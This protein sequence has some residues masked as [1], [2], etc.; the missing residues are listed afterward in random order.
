LI[1]PT[2]VDADAE[3]GLL[4]VLSKFAREA[5]QAAGPPSIAAASSS[6][7]MPWAGEVLEHLAARGQLGRLSSHSRAT[8]RSAG[9]AR[10]LAAGSGRAAAARRARRALGP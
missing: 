1:P 9:L 6:V 5:P 4:G 3:G 2:V 8:R 10:C 7:T